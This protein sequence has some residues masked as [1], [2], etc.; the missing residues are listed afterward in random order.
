MSRNRDLQNVWFSVGI[1]GYYLFTR[2]DNEYLHSV[3]GLCAVRFIGGLFSI[4]L[5]TKNA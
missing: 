4:Q 3:W 1:P 5:I 2:T